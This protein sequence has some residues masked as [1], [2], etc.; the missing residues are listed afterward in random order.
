MNPSIVERLEFQE[1]LD[2]VSNVAPFD[3]VRHCLRE[4]QLLLRLGHVCQ[5]EVGHEG[6]E[7]V[8]KL[9]LAVPLDN[10]LELLREVFVLL[11][12]AL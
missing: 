3:R 1:I 6:D 4:Y 7:T 9:L 12:G 2:Y 10:A 5:A 8:L 11:F